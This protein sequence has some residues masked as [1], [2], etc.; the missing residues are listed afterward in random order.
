[1]T[2][3]SIRQGLACAGLT[4]TL[5]WAPANAEPDIL[6]VAE[7]LQFADGLYSRGLYE[8]AVRE[9]QAYLD[10][11]PAGEGTD[12]A[13]Y[14]MG[15][16]L[17]NLGNTTAA[18]NAFKKVHTDFPKSPFRHKAWFRRAEL[19]ERAGTTPEAIAILHALLKANPPPDLN[20]A[21]LFMLGSCSLKTGD[22]A[23]AATSFES[24]RARHSTSPYY[25]HALLALGNLAATNANT[26]A[27]AA[28]WF[29]IA[30]TN[31]T[32]PRLAAESWY[33][34]AELEFRRGAYDRSITAYQTLFQKFPDDTRAPESRIQL[35]WAL[36]NTR[37]HAEALE[38][39]ANPQPS[40]GGVGRAAEWLYLK[41]N[42]ERQLRNHPAALQSYTDFASRYPAD[43]LATAAAYEKTLTHYRAGQLTEAIDNAKPLLTKP[44]FR[45]D[46]LW[47]MAE[48]YA[49]LKD[50][51]NAAQHYRQLIEQFPASALRRHAMYR[52]GYLL[53]G[54]N[55]HT[56]AATTFEELAK[57][58]PSAEQAPQALFAAAFSYGKAGRSEAATD[59]WAR[60][61]KAY[62]TNAL[63]EEA[64]FQKALTE[65][66][67]HRDA[68]A[69]TSLNTLTSTYPKSPNLPE[70]RYWTG[71]LL[72]STNKFAEAETQ[73]QT[74]L[75]SEPAP[76]LA[77]R[78]KLRLALVL[79]KLDRF[80][81]SATH[82]TSLIQKE[83]AEDVPSELL[84]WLA[85]YQ[86]QKKN[87][88][89]ALAAA[90]LLSGR[91]RED[92]APRQAAFHIAGKSL[93]ALEQWKDA[94]AAFEAALPLVPAG[95]LAAESALYAGD[96]ALQ[97]KDTRAAR[98]HFEKAATLSADDRLLPTR[99][100][101]YAGM[102]RTLK[103]EGNHEEAAKRFY[104]VAILFD[105]AQLV[106]ECLYETAVEYR[107]A[108]RTNESAK[109]ILELKQ[110]FPGNGWLQKL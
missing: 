34:L 12:T 6:P 64:I 41:A 10:Q 4:L 1:M 37:R 51:D 28:T 3:G 43:P 82:I 29:S 8:V 76:E 66:Q 25:P 96:C 49:G 104:S 2:K 78:T 99:V 23:T 45:A 17:A 9:Y 15:E 50:T 81:D 46:L 91:T 13:L 73:W 27:Q 26:A 7:R 106:P 71:I 21:A 65:I 24:V 110:R 62:P 56:N 32:T 44:Q 55:D 72:E 102:A 77:R 97:M 40:T 92:A 83:P 100:E 101:S 87:Y 86:F 61:I 14:R 38:L 105:D 68:D 18:D 59:A 33:Q 109:A 74:L 53:Q 42:C 84:A 88:T 47:V 48:S 63:A 89:N 57:T 93:R 69:L 35:A 95:K 80:D 70:A 58:F 16:S 52:L 79:Q 22:N 30:T 19:A 54:R 85:D 20:A 67:I 36:H 11:V 107:L 39:T 5:S 75:A 98:A 90:N 31:A 94:R 108:G 60:L 103:M